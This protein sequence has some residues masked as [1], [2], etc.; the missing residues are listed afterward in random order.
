M[1]RKQT[2][3][4]LATI[5]GSAVVILDGSVVNLALPKIASEM[6]ASFAD[7]QWII[8]GYLLTLSS[9]ILLGGSLGDILGRKRIYQLGLVGFGIAS[10]VCALAPNVQALIA[11]RIVQGVFGALLVP[12]GLSIINTN[13]P[14]HLRGAAIGKW[15]AWSAVVVPLG[16]LLG[17]YLVDVSSWR[18][19]FLI[20]VPLILL[21]LGLGWVGITE[22]K[23]SRPRRVDWW[24]GIVAMLALAGIT[25]GLIEGPAAGWQIRAT[26]PLLAGVLF[27]A[28]FVWIE[29]K[30]RDPMLDLSLFRSRNFTA[31]NITT[32]AMY[33][34]LSGFLFALVIFLQ[35]TMH[36]SSIAAGASILPITIFLLTLS[37][38]FGALSAKYGPKLFMTAGPIIAGSGMLWLARLQAGQHYL[39]SALPG[40]ILFSFGM[41]L[42]V[43]PLTATVMSSVSASHSGIASGVN[44]AVS[45]VAGLFVIALLGLFG[46]AHAYSFAALLCGGLAVGAGLLSYGFVQNQPIKK[47]V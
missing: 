18:L 17:G 40:V 43:A 5:I 26:G 9:L 24:G 36:Y 15:T 19:I 13:F 31:A 25:Y 20:N 21:S 44:N 1:N 30:R 7:L 29:A 32:F 14:E 12:G 34:A 45:R 22:S 11:M 4:L 28:L 16:P 35:T 6:H 8:D 2:L 37:G 38:R 3:T 41:S 10:L 23:D 46:A 47:S 27:T 39:T 42:L 33:G